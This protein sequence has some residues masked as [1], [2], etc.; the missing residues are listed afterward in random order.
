[1]AKHTKNKSQVLSFVQLK[2][3][4]IKTIENA[5]RFFGASTG[6]IQA[7]PD[8]ALALAQLG[9]EEVGR[10]LT[11]LAA[12]HLPTGAHP[13]EWFWKGW[14]NHQL[15]AH[16][17]YMYEIISPLRLEIVTPD[18]VLFAGQPLRPKISQEKESGLYVDFDHA[19]ACFLSPSEQVSK[20]EAMARTTTLAYLCSTADAVRRAPRGQRFFPPSCL[21]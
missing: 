17:A 18:R 4:Y 20:F 12:F 15:K 5:V 6:L 10:S 13:W 8:K 2:D 1:M 16:R 19:S 7:F 3:G 14:N 11:L 21:R 9:Q